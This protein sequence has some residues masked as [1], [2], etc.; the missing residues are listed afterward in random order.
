MNRIEN[1]LNELKKENKKAFITYMTA[2][3]PDMEKTCD[4]IKAQYEAGIDLIELGIPFSD[5][6]A[7]GPVIQDASY[8]S[9]QNGT[10]LK[11]VFNLVSE[12]RKSCD[13]PLIFMLYYNTVLHYGVEKFVDRCIECGVD[14]IIVPDLPYE[15][16][17]EI[18]EYMNKKRMLHFLYR[19]FLQFQKI[20][21][22]CL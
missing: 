21:Y 19:L 1:R 5:P 22:L 10:N 12:L 11:G 17:F 18:V 13:V 20:E 3:F 16:S 15:E 6:I 7:D 2:G 4:I 9:I 8:R 14:G